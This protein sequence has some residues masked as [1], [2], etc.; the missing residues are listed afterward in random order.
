MLMATVV[1]HTLSRWDSDGRYLRP[2]ETSTTCE[3]LPAATSTRRQL[4]NEME[5]RLAGK[6]IDWVPFVSGTT[7]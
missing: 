2:P 6:R 1:Q 5:A 7:T 3:R 4:N